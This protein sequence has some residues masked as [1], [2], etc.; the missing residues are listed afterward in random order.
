MN[1]MDTI[2]SRRTI[3]SYT[4]EGLCETELADILKAAN[5][6]PVGRGQFQN[7]HLT[8]ISDPA[9][10]SEIDAAG[11]ADLGKQPG[12][13]LYGAPLL[14]LVSAVVTPGIENVGYSNAAIM[15]QNMA[16][17]AADMGI[18]ACHI[19]GAVRSLNERPQLLARLPIPE[20]F[21]ACCALALGKTDEVY[22]LR[23]IPE[24]KFAKSFVK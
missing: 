9:L 14:I 13:V 2:C 16:L 7:V 22:E 18:G 5:A 10:V 11:A 21:T 17:A 8:V 6:S 19:W 4:G 23:D 24:D 3:R 12:Q 20:G 15:V 1:T